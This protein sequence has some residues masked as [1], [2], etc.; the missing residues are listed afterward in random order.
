MPGFIIS[1]LV[2]SELAID[3]GT[4]NTVVYAPGRGIVMHEPS[5]MAIQERPDGSRAVISIGQA[6]KDMMGKT[7]PQV[8][9]VCPLRH[10]AVT[11]SHLVWLLMQHC[12]KQTIRSR[13]GRPLRVI[14]GV[15]PGSSAVEC[16][17]MVE[18]AEAAGANDVCLIY[19]PLAAA[20]G[21]GLA[22][23]EPYGHM[24][25]DMGGGR[26]DIAIISLG[27]VVSSKTLPLGGEAM[28][29]A[30]RRMVRHK[31]QLDIGVQTAERLKQT[32]GSMHACAPVQRMLIKGT[33]SVTGAP[34]AQKVLAKDVQAVLV[35]F[36]ERLIA[37]IQE[38]FAATSPELAAD[39]IE[40][41][42]TFTGGGALLD[43]LIPYVD[44][45]LGFP[46]Q[47]ASEPIAC[48]AMGAGKVFEDPT[49]R[50][51]VTMRM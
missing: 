48:V 16:R 3:L 2:G 34:R 11:D 1:S 49:L 26:T 8:N 17:A 47:L 35:D 12:I 45:A 51:Q 24:V 41:G 9:T 32:L 6:A 19:A 18:P 44:A 4:T 5:V 14:L 39:I 21:A 33:D 31:Y 42:V 30:V 10:G 43:G 38:V 29:M 37:A 25:V 40:T 23:R 15:P 7:P 50:Q 20:L 46:V 13:M 27:D 22:I 36:L 28:D